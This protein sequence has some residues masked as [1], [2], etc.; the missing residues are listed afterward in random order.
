MAFHSLSLKAVFAFTVPQNLKSI[1]VM[2]KLEICC[3]PHR[4]IVLTSMCQLPRSS[5]V[6]EIL[7]ASNDREL[8]FVIEEAQCGV[9][10]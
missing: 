8:A 5:E 9:W 7:H 2:E 3:T 6:E 10:W 4:T 1:R